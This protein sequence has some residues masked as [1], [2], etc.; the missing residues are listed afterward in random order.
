[1]ARRSTESLQKHTL[2]LRKGDIDRL[3]E[4]YPSRNPT[5]LVRQIVSR[6]VDNQTAS[7]ISVAEQQAIIDNLESEQ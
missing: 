4:L 1:M 5:V 2:N 3:A 6:F 7:V